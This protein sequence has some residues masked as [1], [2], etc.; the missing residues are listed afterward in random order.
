MFDRVLNMHLETMAQAC[1]LIE[2]MFSHWRFEF[3]FNTYSGV[4]QLHQKLKSLG[5]SCVLNLQFAI[6]GRLLG[7]TAAPNYFWYN[8]KFCTEKF[9]D[10]NVY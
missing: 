2:V 1:F 7:A 5:Y 9:K 6:K 8:S 3:L 4:L 10:Y